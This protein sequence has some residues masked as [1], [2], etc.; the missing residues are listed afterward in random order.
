MY[1]QSSGIPFQPGSIQSGIAVANTTAS[2][3]NVT[4]ELFN[5]DGSPTGVAPV[6]LAVPASGQIAEFLSQIFSN[7]PQSFQG[8]VLRISSQS[9][10]SV[11][12]LRGRT[13]ERSDFLITTTP[14]TLESAPATSAEFLFPHLVNGGGY[15]S[16]FIVFSGTA[17]QA[18]IGT[19][20]FFDQKGNPLPLSLQ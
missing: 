14:S 9:A 19:L 16:Q 20:H 2:A 5:P 6:T 12:G 3:A 8:G 13:N 1:V 7:L 11:V 4:F 15:T 18:S 17:G 10:I